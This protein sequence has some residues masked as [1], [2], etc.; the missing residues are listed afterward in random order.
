MNSQ[1]ART[2]ARTGLMTGFFGPVGLC[3]LALALSAT[4]MAAKLRITH[5]PGAP[6]YKEPI[7]GQPFT[8]LPLNRILDAE[9]KQG[10]FW[11]ITFDYNGLKTTGY[12]HEFLVEEVTESDLL[13]SAAPLGPI[14]TQAGLAAEIELKIEESRYL[15]VQERDLP[16][17]VESLRSLVPKVF[18]LEDLQKQRQL[19]CDIYHWTGQALSK[20]GE[21]ARAIKE[22][23]NMFEVDYLTAKRATKYVSDPNISQ[24]I[25]TAEKQYNGTFVGYS[26]QVDTEPKEAV[27]KIDGKVAGQSPDVITIDRPKITLEIEKE[28]Y[29]PEKVVL[30]LTEAKTVKSYVLQSV[31]RTIHVSSDPPGAAVFL[32]GRDTGKLTEC[33]LGYVPFGPHKLAVKKDRYADWEEEITVSEGAGPLSMTVVLPPKTYFSVFVWGGPESKAFIQPKALAMDKDGNF[34][35]ADDGPMKVRKF[36]RDRGAQLSWG[37]EGK[38]FKSLKQPSGIVIDGEG[39]CYVTDAK[40]ASVTKFDKKGKLVLKWGKPGAKEGELA[41]P[42]GIA[43]DKN[44]DIYVVDSAN[45]RIV[46]YSSAGVLKKTWGVPGPG[47]GQ[48]YLPTAVAVT[49]QNEVVVVDAGR[50]QKFTSDGVFIDAFAKPESA[51]AE[52]KRPLGICC[53][54]YDNIYVADAGANRVLKFQSNGRFI[55]SFGG[56]GIDPGQMMG[57]VAVAVNEKGSVFVLEKG[58]RR[59]QEFQPPS[60]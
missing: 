35:V 3:L 52:F 50:I 40:G 37:D 20:Q 49:R 13:G 33:D 28:G 43:V 21:D 22:F 8:T 16:Q 59:I 32:D 5:P 46:K 1:R 55:G 15:I 47:Q 38:A 23:K 14:K 60:K 25:S 7:L 44:N 10:E 36:N 53:D 12:V 34:Y 29:K 58:N 42:M 4:G 2:A 57:L 9:V 17:Q 18:G 51:E 54:G 30:S 39:N 24:L 56:N 48:F 45:S 27:L 11:K 26:L 6:I 41:Q 31:A 19:A